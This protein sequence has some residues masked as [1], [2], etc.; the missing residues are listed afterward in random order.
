MQSIEININDPANKLSMSDRWLRLRKRI[1]DS[2][3]LYLYLA[4]FAILF[5]VFTVLP[6]IISIYLSF[7]Y[8]N[9]LEAPKW[10]G[11]Q[12]YIR[13]FL[14]DDVFLIALKNTFIFAIITGPVSYMASLLIA[15]MINE[16]KPKIRAFFTLLFYAPSISGN[17]YLVWQYFFHND[18]YGYANAIL[19][20]LGIIHEPI[21]WLI[22]PRYI[23]WIVIIVVLWMSLGT[24]FLVFIAGLQNVD[25]SLYEAGAIDGI[26]NRW[27]ELWY[28]TLPCMRPQLMFGAIMAITQSFA[29]SQQSIALAGFPSVDYAARTIVTHLVDYGSVRFEMGY[30]AAIATLLFF[31][32]IIIQRIVQGML[33]KVGE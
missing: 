4:P 8:Y 1:V 18:P 24:S 16:F 31:G 2:K 11:W 5:F 9:M 23:L 26:K 33:N 14:A 19:M 27:Q 21:L 20:D 32:M 25:N 17:A 3:E 12:N 13:L 29:A 28:I 6:V 7:T 30:A 15:W 22:D 10:V